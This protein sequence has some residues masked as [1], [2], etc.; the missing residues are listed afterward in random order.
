MN[1]HDEN[2]VPQYLK[3]L[4]ELSR[5]HVEIGIIGD[6]DKYKGSDITVLGVATVHE[7]GVNVVGKNGKRI[8]I[9][10]RSFIRTSYD[11]NKQRIFEFDKELERVLN[12]ELSVDGFFNLVGEF[13]VGVIQN[14]LTS[15]VNS[16]PLAEST[17]RAKGSSNPLIDTGQLRRSIDY[18]I[19][20]S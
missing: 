14:H 11:A 13:A 12:L 4:K 2:K 19:V 17:I 15:Q 18:K 9:P 5:T 10:E 7:F 20:R 8:N 1:I 16:P 3:M 6:G